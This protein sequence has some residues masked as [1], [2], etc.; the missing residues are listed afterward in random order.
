MLPETKCPAVCPGVRH[1]QNWYN[2]AHTFKGWWIINAGIE[3]QY[4]QGISTNNLGAAVKFRHVL[5]ALTIGVMHF[6]V[7]NDSTLYIFVLHVFIT[8]HIKITSFCS[9]AVISIIL[10]HYHNKTFPNPIS[11]QHFKILEIMI[12][13]LFQNHRFTWPSCVYFLQ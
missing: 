12:V 6:R 3:N 8:S 1:N 7:P 4:K 11:T 5:K 9:H 13:Q 2:S 10:K